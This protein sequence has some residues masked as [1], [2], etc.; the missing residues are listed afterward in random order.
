M[1]PWRQGPPLPRSFQRSREKG[2]QKGRGN[3]NPRYP[4]WPRYP[5]HPNLPPPLFQRISTPPSPHHLSIF[6]KKRS[7]WCKITVETF[8]GWIYGTLIFFTLTFV[9]SW[10]YF[11][12]A[13]C[14]IFEDGK[15]WKKIKPATVRI[16]IDI[17]PLSFLHFSFLNSL[18]P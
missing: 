2:W 1:A 3:Q 8:E 18:K 14:T 17:P 11:L 5:C 16:L 6:P 4:S 7:D 12:D 15:L 13:G 10:R 9:L